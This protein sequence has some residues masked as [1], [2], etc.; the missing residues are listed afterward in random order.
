MAVTDSLT[1]PKLWLWWH[2]W[3]SM[4][5]LAALHCKCVNADVTVHWFM[6]AEIGL[7]FIWLVFWP[8]T[9]FK[10]CNILKSSDCY[11][12]RAIILNCQNQF[13]SVR[14]R[15]NIYPP[16]RVSPFAGLPAVKF[17]IYHTY[18]GL[19]MSC[20]GYCDIFHS[21]L[22]HWNI[23]FNAQLCKHHPQSLCPLV[24]TP[25]CT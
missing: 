22:L 20:E 15:F 13:L 21:F 16:I 4:Q 2:K 9:L 12:R 17:L 10:K 6:R 3:N 14:F 19:M 1:V 8:Q 24:I 18:F 23:L 25:R 7:T 5:S 11:H